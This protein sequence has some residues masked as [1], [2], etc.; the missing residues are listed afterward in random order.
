MSKLTDDEF[1]DALSSEDQLG[2]VI[3]GHI[4]LEH[5]LD[6]FLLTAM[7]LYENYEKG[8]NADYKTK[9]LMCCALGL[10]PE[11]QGPLSAVGT[12][13]NKFAHLPSYKLTESDV[14]N[15]YAS[16]SSA[17]KQHLK[18][19]FLILAR[20]FQRESSS[21]VKIDYIERLNLIFMLLHSKLKKAN[22]QLIQTS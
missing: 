16:L 21:F 6:N 8:I 12:L 10:A 17:H 18:Q 4:H 14:N 19:A 11:L 1:Y 2:M 7:P 5:W 9:V 22:A 13:R 20:R 3:R 15:L